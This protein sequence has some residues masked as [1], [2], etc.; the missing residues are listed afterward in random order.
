V[1][2][3]QTRAA[4]A[5]EV[6]HGGVSRLLQRDIVRTGRMTP[7]VA[8]LL[9]R[10]MTFRQDADYT[11]EYVFTASIA[12]QSIDDARAFASAARVILATDGWI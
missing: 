12:Q 3:L 10:L 9:S 2:E 11:A 5:A 7:E 8:V 4:V 1:T 6:A